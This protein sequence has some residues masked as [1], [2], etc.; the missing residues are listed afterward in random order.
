ME[1]FERYTDVPKVAAFRDMVDLI[2]RNVHQ[3]VLREFQ[4]L[5]VISDPFAGRG[6][7]LAEGATYDEKQR[8][9]TEQEQVA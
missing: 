1:K 4:L 9:R 7:T 6:L 8:V 2:T 3:Q 5:W